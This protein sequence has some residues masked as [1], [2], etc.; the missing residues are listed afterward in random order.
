MLRRVAVVLELPD[1]NQKQMIPHIEDANPEYYLRWVPHVSSALASVAVNLGGQI[2]GIVGQVDDTDMFA[3]GFC[4]DMLHR[5]SP[6]P[7]LEASEIEALLAQIEA[8]YNSVANSDLSV[9]LRDRLLNHLTDMFTALNRA[10]VGGLEE[11]RS[12]FEQTLGGIASD[13]SLKTELR[14]ERNTDWREKLWALLAKVAVVVTLSAPLVQLTAPEA[15]AHTPGT[16][17]TIVVDEPPPPAP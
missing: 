15:P 6:Q 12:A 16:N 1:Q 14:D 7:V 9:E 10:R 11:L 13:E 17:I 8:L 5:R 4:E 3:L 2:G